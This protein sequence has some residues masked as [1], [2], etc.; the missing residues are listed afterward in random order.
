MS[1]QG[2][3]SFTDKV[4]K[5]VMPDSQKSGMDKTKDKAS[6]GMDSVAGSMQPD[7]MK[8]DSQKAGDKG[9]SMYEQTKD[10]I[11]NTFS[12]DNKDSGDEASDDDFDAWRNEEPLNAYD[13][14]L[15]GLLR[16]PRRVTKAELLSYMPP[17]VEADALVSLWFRVPHPYKAIIHAPQFQ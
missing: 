13:E 17:K 5:T 14:E 15:P 11:S 9:S 1:D 8:S 10:T 12:S 2:R 3:E 4:S 16:S 6:G 7:S